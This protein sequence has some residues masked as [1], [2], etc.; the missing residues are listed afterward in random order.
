M[1]TYDHSGMLEIKQNSN[2]WLEWRRA[3][4]GSSDVSALFN[5]SPWKTAYQLWEEKTGKKD[6]SV[7]NAATEKGYALEAKARSLYELHKGFE[8]PPSLVVS[9][10][11]DFM[12]CSLDGW[13]K[14]QK[15]IVEIKCPG[16]PVIELAKARLAPEYYNIQMQYQLM[17]TSAEICDYVVFDGKEIVIIEIK[18][19]EEKQKEI[20]KKVCE[21]WDLVLKDSPPPLS[22][23]DYKEFDDLAALSDLAELNEILKEKKS[24][25]AKEKELREKIIDKMDHPRMY[26]S[27]VRVIRIERAGTV[28]WKKVE[29]DYGVDPEKYRKAPVISYQF[30]QESEGAED[31]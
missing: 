19:D 3:G 16:K 2:E 25:E 13:A 20:F 30:R 28:D 18:P 14:E 17:L 1:I 12:R 7:S 6:H 21:F 29:K 27:G 26:G 8:A 9:D 15:R 24:L 31:E 23:K 4:I 5:I 11:Y 22:D 10:E